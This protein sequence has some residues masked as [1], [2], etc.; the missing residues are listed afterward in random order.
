MKKVFIFFVLLNLFL[1][2]EGRAMICD[3]EKPITHS[4]TLSSTFNAH[5]DA[6]RESLNGTSPTKKT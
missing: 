5:V 3:I 2:S 1:F 6:F 4:R